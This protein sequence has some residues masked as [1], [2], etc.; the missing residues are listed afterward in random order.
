ME[1]H[2]MFHWI[3]QWFIL[4]VSLPGLR[5][6]QIMGKAL[7][8]GISVRVFLEDIGLWISGL[9]KEDPPSTWTDTI[10]LAE[11]LYKTEGRGKGNWLSL[12]WSWA[13]FLLLGIGTQDS[14]AFGVKDLQQILPHPLSSQASDSEV[15]KCGLSLN[16][17]FP[18]SLS[19]WQSIM[20]LLSLSN[21]M[22]LFL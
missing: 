16:T 20:E 1:S 2:K 7:F 5:D 10:Q 12:F 14:P 17:S 3:L 8:L 18:G 11:G 22:S 19:C 15:F 21:C 4:G 13:A 9:R 6:M